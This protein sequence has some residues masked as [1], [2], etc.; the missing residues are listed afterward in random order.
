MTRT[1][2]PPTTDAMKKSCG[3]GVGGECGGWETR[4]K[5]HTLTF[6][7]QLHTSV[8]AMIASPMS[9]SPT[10]RMSAH[11]LDTAP[12]P[13]FALVAVGPVVEAPAGAVCV[14]FI[15]AMIFTASV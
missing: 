6:P 13:T 2:K 4:R 14:G 3:V 11:V 9:T 7:L 8:D 5:L 15:A 10:A 12:P 1:L